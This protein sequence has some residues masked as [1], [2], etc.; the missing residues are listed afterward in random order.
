M[1]MFFIVT[2]VDRSDFNC[3]QPAARRVVPQHRL[4]AVG[5][6]SRANR[7]QRAHGLVH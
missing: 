7:L 3:K 2:G 5:Q 6:V 4:A 1:A